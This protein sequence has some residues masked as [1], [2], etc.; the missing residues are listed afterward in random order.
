MAT[1]APQAGSRQPAIPLSDHAASSAAMQP[2]L[3][4]ARRVAAVDLPVLI[5]GESGTG[6][7]RL[8]RA[9]HDASP[10]AARPF[11]VLDCAAV[12]G[13]LLESELFGHQRGAFTGA[14]DDRAGVFE[15]ADT[16][17]LLLDQVDLMP[18]S[19]QVRLLRVLEER[20]VQ[21]LGST[22]PRAVD[23][24]IVSTT[25]A[26]LN[27][28]VAAGTF[29]QDLY[30]RLHVVPITLPPL[31]DRAEDIPALAEELLAGITADWGRPAARLTPGALAALQRHTWPGNIRELE[32]TLRRAVAL[33][34][35]PDIDE[36][37]VVPESQRS[38][39]LTMQLAPDQRL[40]IHPDVTSIRQTTRELERTLILRALERT[41]GNRTHAARLLDI[42]LRA[43][44]YKLKD[45][46]DPAEVPPA[47]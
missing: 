43:L 34:D 46:F 38:A 31:R 29:R 19:L 35:T 39:A 27:D 23:V 16:G 2:V 14:T 15:L 24:R 28:L 42:S 26:E 21:R 47:P 37:L 20:T 4:A 32:N 40:W 17:T 5:T 44:L 6:K 41:G 45:L 8:A 36:P 12:S 10:R 18:E 9:I 30:Y 33:A 11:R 25:T 13:E 1:R 22:T 7:G 3:R